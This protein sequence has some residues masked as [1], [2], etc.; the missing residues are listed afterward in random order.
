MELIKDK[1]IER[2]WRFVSK[3]SCCWLWLG[4]HNGTGYGKFWL[5][6]KTVYAHRF[7]FLLHNGLIEPGYEID[8]L[9]KNRMCVNPDHLELVTPKEN[10]NRGNSAA[11]KNIK[12]THCDNG[13]ELS[14][15]NL[16]ED[17]LSRGHKVCKKCRE[18][19]D[20]RRL[21]LIENCEDFSHNLKLNKNDVMLILS[22]KNEGN[23]SCKEIAEKFNVKIKTIYAIIENRAW[24]KL[25]RKNE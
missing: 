13:H 8:H 25:Q 14:E 10:R 15:D 4:S 22:M 6:G 24:K 11:G 5:N 1:D 2:F 16:C 12:R 20:R 9:C 17:Y 19:Q 7:S 18:E 21:Y 3:D 23:I